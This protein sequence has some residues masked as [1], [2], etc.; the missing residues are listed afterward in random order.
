M[1]IN[2][3]IVSTKADYASQLALASNM[4]YKMIKGSDAN[5]GVGIQ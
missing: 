5:N 3:E 4:T 1:M 2:D